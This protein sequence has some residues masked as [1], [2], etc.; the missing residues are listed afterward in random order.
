MTTIQVSQLAVLNL[1][2]GLT[3][4]IFYKIQY[5]NQHGVTAFPLK[6]TGQMVNIALTNFTDPPSIETNDDGKGSIRVVSI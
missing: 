3:I 2:Q 1:I 4:C 5:A 6:Q